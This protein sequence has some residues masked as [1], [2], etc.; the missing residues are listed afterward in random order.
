VIAPRWW[1]VYSVLRGVLNPLLDKRMERDEGIQTVVRE[2]DRKS[3]AT[4]DGARPGE[5]AAA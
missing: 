1:S 2:G 4:E 3:Q 5:R